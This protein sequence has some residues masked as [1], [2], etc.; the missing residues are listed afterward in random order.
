MNQE[1]SAE[2]R[3][4]PKMDANVIR[5]R[6][7]STLKKVIRH[8]Q[9]ALHPGEDEA[10]LSRRHVVIELGAARKLYDTLVPANWDD[11]AEIHK[12]RLKCYGNSYL[13]GFC[14]KLAPKIVVETGVH[15]GASSAFILQAL[16]DNNCGKLYSIDLPDQQYLRDDGSIHHDVFNPNKVGFAVPET[17]RG[18]WQLVLGDAKQKLPEILAALDSIDIFHHDSMHTYE[19]MQF[20]YNTAWPKLKAGGILMSDDVTWNDA[21]TDFCR[22]R[23]VES[24]TIRGAGWAFKP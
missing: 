11:I 8:P 20:E 3:G 9:L 22:D 24:H 4:P 16:Y 23:N 5:G 21:F 6:L 2:E 18:K 12:S 17:L 15:Y 10:K 14:R 7:F 19:H 1:V 13:Y